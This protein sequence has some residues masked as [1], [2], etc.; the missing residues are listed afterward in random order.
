[1]LIDTDED[2]R[3]A[4]ARRSRLSLANSQ[5]ST[6]LDEFETESSSLDGKT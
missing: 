6:R 1:V 2:E 3:I 4:K 5:A